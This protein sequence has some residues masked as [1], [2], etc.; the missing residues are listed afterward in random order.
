MSFIDKI[1]SFASSAFNFLKGDGIA[2]NLA[3]TALIGLALNKLQKSTNKDNETVDPGTEVTIDPDTQYSVP[4]LYG[5]AFIDGKITDAKMDA[6][7]TTLWVCY[8]LCEKTGNLIDG[9]ASAISFNEIYI[10][11]FRLSLNDTGYTVDSIF[12]D[13]GNSG[14]VWAN[15]I[16]VYPFSGGSTSPVSFTTEAAGNTA[17]A[18]DLMPHWTSTDTMNDLVFCIVKYKYNKKQK[19]TTIGQNV[20]FK[21]TNTMSQPGDVLND[22]LQNTRYGAGVPAAEIDLV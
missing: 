12:D 14:T 6:N 10:D 11:N 1:G 16:E 9:S 2:N 13:D 18:Y 4:V 3:R 5:S 15:L 22:Y 20:K 7:N 17:N 21:L 8:T 19:L